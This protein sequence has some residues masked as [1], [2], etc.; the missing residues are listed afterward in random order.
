MHSEG[1]LK[2]GFPSNKGIG[3]LIELIDVFLLLLTSVNVHAY[4]V[5]DEKS[6]KFN[7]IIWKDSS[8][9]MK[10]RNEPLKEVREDLKQIIEENK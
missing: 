5:M 1:R 10:I 2:D 4:S 6:G 9:V 7:L 8:G 3:I